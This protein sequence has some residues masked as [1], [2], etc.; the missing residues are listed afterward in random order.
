MLVFATGGAKIHD[1]EEGCNKKKVRHNPRC[2]LELR[3][4]VSVIRPTRRKESKPRLSTSQALGLRTRR[5]FPT[6]AVQQE[7]EVQLRKP[8]SGDQATFNLPLEWPIKK[9]IKQ[10]RWFQNLKVIPT[11]PQ[12]DLPRMACHTFWSKVHFARDCPNPWI[13]TIRE[14]FQD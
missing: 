10:G 7:E 11:D 8:P 12:L 1:S 3:H 14:L 13:Q 5:S 4:L 2:H 9:V 6:P